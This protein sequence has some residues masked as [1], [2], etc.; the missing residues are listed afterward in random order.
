M[1]E[2]LCG[3]IVILNPAHR[4]TQVMARLANDSWTFEDG[5]KAFSFYCE[6]GFDQ[7]GG[8]LMLTQ[9]EGPEKEK[10][11]R[12]FYV[13]YEAIFT[14]VGVSDPDDKQFGFTSRG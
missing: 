2:Q 9:L 10:P 14:M 12:A 1:A 7:I 5:T 11:S 4:V 6:P 3:Y 13:P 8:G